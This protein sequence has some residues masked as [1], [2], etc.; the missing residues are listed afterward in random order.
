MMGYLTAAVI[1]IIHF[2]LI[3]TFSFVIYSVHNTI[4]KLGKKSLIVKKWGISCLHIED[5][6]IQ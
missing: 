3:Y 1:S 2:L 6:F 4:I 5:L